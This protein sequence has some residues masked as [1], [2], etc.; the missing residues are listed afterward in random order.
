MT[1]I[2]SFAAAAA[3]WQNFYLLTGTA[4]ATLIGLMFVAVSFGAGLIGKQSTDSARSFIEP[5]FYHFVYVLIIACLVLVPAMT[6]PALATLLVVMSV[7]RTAVL[8]RVFRHMQEAQR[9]YGDI[10]RSDWLAGIV[11][12][13]LC[14]LLLAGSAVGFFAG[15]SASFSGLALAT[16][17]MLVLGI[18]AA[19]ELMIWMALVRSRQNP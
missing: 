18:F 14:Y 6:A 19:W 17:A 2:P 7:W 12:P 1:P 8:F 9:A 13:G 11:V 4:A 16:L 10:E 3:A 5:P 15:Y